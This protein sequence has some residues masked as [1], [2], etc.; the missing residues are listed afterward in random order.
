MDEAVAAVQEENLVLAERLSRRA[1]DAGKVNPRLW[2]DHARILEHCGQPD[3]ADEAVRQAIALAPLYAEAFAELARMQA[4]KGKVVQAV[5]LQRRAVELQPD[6]A[7]AADALRAYEVLLPDAPSTGGSGAGGSS[8]APAASAD[9]ARMERTNRYDWEAIDAELRDQGMARIP[10]LINANECAAL[11]GLW[12]EASAFEHEVR[13]GGWSDGGA[14]TYRFF[15]RPLPE[16][17]GDLRNELYARLAVIANAWNERLG[18]SER[19]PGV[20]ADFTA[21]CHDAGQSR[22]TPILLR[23]APGGFNAPHNDIAGRVVF[24]FQLAVTLGPGN[25]EDDGGGELQLVDARPGKKVRAHRLG[26][27]C[28]DGVVFCTRERLV[29]IAGALGLQPV[30]HGVT[31]VLGRERFALGIPFHEHG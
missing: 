1:I 25:T 20:L 31:E 26:T 14:V 15:T 13:R 23:Y 3:E 17:V 29:S 4:S 30:L 24:P 28:G 19:L 22:T 6:N 2:L 9:S 27:G 10:N 12:D 11:I 8:E 16:L 7:G 5:R 18:R 21:R